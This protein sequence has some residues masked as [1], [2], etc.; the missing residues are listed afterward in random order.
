[1]SASSAASEL[2]DPVTRYASA[3][4]QGEVVACKAVIEACQRHL[5]DLVSAGGRG[6]HFDAAAALDAIEFAALLP[7]IKGPLAGKPFVL[8][9]FEAFIVGS[10]FGW[11]RS[12]GTRRF[13]VAYVEIP[14]KNGKS[15]LAAVIVLL[16][17]FFDGEL[18]AE[19][20]CVATKRDQAKIVWEIARDMVVRTEAL[21]RRLKVFKGTYVISDYTTSSKLEALGARENTLHGLNPN[22]VSID[23]VHAHANRGIV[24]VMTSAVGA[25]PQ[26]LLF[27][28]TTAG[29][30]RQSVCYQH[31]EHTHKVTSRILEDDSWFGFIASIDEG[32]DWQDPQTW[33]K[34]N[35]NLDV[36]FPRSYLDGEFAKALAMPA[37]QNAFKRLHLNIWTEQAERWIDMNRWAACDQPVDEGALAGLSCWGGLDLS[38][39]LDITAL[40]L[41]FPRPSG[42]Y[43]VVRR[44]WVPE[45][46]IQK[47][48][49]DDRVPYDVWV[50]QGYIKAT[51]GNVIDYDFI[52]HEVRAL[53]KR[54]QIHELAYDPWNAMQTAI[55]LQAEGLPMVEF[56]QGFRSMS[57]PCKQLEAAL[58]AGKLRTGADPVLRWMAS[59]AAVIHDASENV[60]IAKDRCYE[61][62]DGI[63]ALVMA[64]GRAIVTEGP[65]TS[66]YD[67]R[68]VV[69]LGGAP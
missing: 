57:E 14:R 40:V 23:E 2:L 51:P 38:Q 24:D 29:F 37:A 58:V 8:E 21:R 28:I 22:G 10:L 55:H 56:R 53:A 18:G 4:V 46:R 61:R 19:V 33:Y 15:C 44:F 50:R 11:L 12:D 31:H 63:V 25:R 5:D 52:E 30:D 9:P 65:K 39:K 3:V 32:D 54:F 62:V 20:Y 49:R 34:A 43:Q 42:T 7:H 67:R 36:S 69:V 64:L 13:R 66:V 1:M 6:L 47:R 35:P 48:V 59:N 16:L 45:D 68:G 41:V 26:P 17:A 60:R 27:E